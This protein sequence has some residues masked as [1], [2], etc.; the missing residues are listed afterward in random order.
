MNISETEDKLDQ[1]K[2]EALAFFDSA[3]N[4]NPY[5][6]SISGLDSDANECW[7]LLDIAQQNVSISLQKDLLVI[8]SEIIP[9]LKSSP[10]LNDA[11]ERDIGILTKKMRASLRLRWFRFYDVD[12]IHDEGQFLAVSP[13]SQSD[14][15]PYE[16]EKSKKLFVECL[17]QLASMLDLISA[18]PSYLPNG[19]T[20]KNPN[21]TQEYRPNTAFVMMR[22]DPNN[23]ELEDVYETYKLCFSMFGITTVRADGIE[24]ADVITDRI[25]QEI[26]TSQFLLGDLTEERP[27]VYYEIGYAHSLG[28]SVMMYRK[29]KTKIHFDLAAYNCPEYKNMTE[30]KEL[31]LKR[32][33]Q[34]TNRK[35]KSS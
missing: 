18:S 19:L 1:L 29:E 7:N 26:K 31:L 10:L 33:E 2:Q 12:V 16:P 11:D 13:P 22:I 35:P 20:N 23:H 3:S 17:D 32:L 9:I 34:T 21:L 4:I 30:L 8:I 6:H 25:I 5:E 27:S 15:K 28:R 24:H 14:D